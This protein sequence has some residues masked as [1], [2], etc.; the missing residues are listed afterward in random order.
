MTGSEKLALVR[1]LYESV[2]EQGEFAVDD[3]L[4]SPDEIYH[5]HGVD[6]QGGPEWDKDAARRFRANFRDLRIRLELTV[7]EAD[8]LAVLWRIEGTHVETGKEIGDYTGVNIFRIVDGRVVE[9]WNTRD[10]LGLYAQIGVIPPR[11]ELATR[12]FTRPAQA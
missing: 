8:L 1:R 5:Q 10:D 9:V 4:I 11:S 12:V 2:W 6:G 3:E 7:E